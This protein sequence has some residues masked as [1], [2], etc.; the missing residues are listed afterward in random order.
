MPKQ[1]TLTSFF[2]ETEASSSKKG[3]SAK[4]RREKEEGVA[5][6]QTDDKEGNATGRR[7]SKQE[8]SELCGVRLESSET[9]RHPN[10][11]RSFSAKNRKIDRYS[12]GKLPI[13]FK[14]KEWYDGSDTDVEVSITIGSLKFE[15]FPDD[16]GDRTESRLS[17]DNGAYNQVGLLVTLIQDAK[18][19]KKA[20][21]LKAEMEE[22]SAKEMNRHWNILAKK[23]VCR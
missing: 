5:A 15:M 4:T 1:T 17:M 20:K 2:G 6:A 22:G 23:A 16:W 7:T 19:R 10:F 12:L 13:E 8:D 3:G 21:V 18:G 14:S 9:L 11:G